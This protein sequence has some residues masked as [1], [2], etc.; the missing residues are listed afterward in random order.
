MA[1]LMY[2]E[3]MLGNTFIAIDLGEKIRGAVVSDLV[4]DGAVLE[5]LEDRIEGRFVAADVKNPTTGEIIVPVNTM[6]SKSQAKYL[7]FLILIV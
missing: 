6:V 5:S 1:D 3:L 4:Q 7:D 2:V